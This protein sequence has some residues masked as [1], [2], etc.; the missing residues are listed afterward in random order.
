MKSEKQ[1][2]ELH[3]KSS[4]RPHVFIFTINIII[5]GCL[6]STLYKYFSLD[7]TLTINIGIN[8]AVQQRKS[9]L[10]CTRL[11]Y[12]LHAQAD[13][14]LLLQV[15][16]LQCESKISQRT[17]YSPG[18]MSHHFS[19]KFYESNLHGG[20]RRRTLLACSEWNNSAL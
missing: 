7:V 2:D 11:A 17:F 9:S 5:T 10:Q 3:N 16:N 6:S 18:E 19:A 4:T 12:D 15:L 20:H 8:T 1:P 13:S 14:L